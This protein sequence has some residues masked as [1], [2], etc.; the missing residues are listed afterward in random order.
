MA[1][2]QLY[3]APADEDIQSLEEHARPYRAL[4]DHWERTQWTAGGID[5][6]TDAANFQALSPEQQQG[7]LWIFS[8][9]FHAEFSVATVLSPFI[10]AAPSYEAQLLLAAQISDEFK[11]MQCVLRIYEEVFGVKGGIPAI[12]SIA[13]STSDPI[14]D[15]FYE[16][17]ESVVG[18]LKHDQCEDTFLHAVMAYH[19]IAEGV[20]AR[21]AQHLAGDQYAA[22][23]DF[24]GLAMGQKLVS[25]DEA[26]HIGFGVTYARQRLIDDPI[27]SR[28][29]IAAG[30]EEFATIAAQGFDLVGGDIETTVMRGYGVDASTFYNELLRLMDVRL[31]SIG[32]TE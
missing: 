31:R 13:A 21:C 29:I 8:H 27:R 3:E 9:R 12:R 32:F 25:R 18:E 10:T 24:P 23:G 2:Q 22:L 28:E 26:R 5:F 4:Y 11:H 19:L 16:R 30:L 1:I 6:R 14:A 17:F 7:L 20:V 15:F